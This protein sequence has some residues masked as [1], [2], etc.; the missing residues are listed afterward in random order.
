MWGHLVTYS[1]FLLSVC[2]LAI[3]IVQLD[4]WGDDSIRIRIAP[5][6]SQIV[7]PP[8]M[9]LDSPT[10]PTLTT[11]VEGAGTQNVANGNLAVSVD[12]STGLITAT[13]MSD[14]AVLLRQTSVS[15]G[16]AAPGSRAGSVSATVSFAG[17]PGEKVY[18][19]GEHRTGTVNQMPYFQLFQ[20]SQ[21]YPDS[22]G[23][24]VSIPYYGSSI[25]YGFLW[26]LPSYGWVNLT[27]TEIAWFYAECGLLADNY[28]CANGPVS[29]SLRRS[30]APHG[31][32]RRTR[33]SDALLRN[34]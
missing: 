23:G 20:N 3:P 25:G 31:R 32:R 19:L 30:S 22:H 21:Y 14:G 9:A 13:R 15:F 34:R 10:P 8:L 6:G 4:A 17:T 28:E 27:E 5:P 1:L 24:D 2:S 12:P 26:N 29:I 7:D 16:A 18:G 11:R 33:S